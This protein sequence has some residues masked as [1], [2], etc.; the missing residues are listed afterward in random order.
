MRSHGFE[1]RNRRREESLESAS[2]S[3]SDMT[4][5]KDIQRNR[6]L[7]FDE[8]EKLDSPYDQYTQDNIGDNQ[9]LYRSVPCDQIDWMM[10]KFLN[11]DPVGKKLRLPVLRLD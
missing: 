3:S 5:I 10:A 4:P 9:L 8:E 7:V 1:S 11:S 6:I 2:A